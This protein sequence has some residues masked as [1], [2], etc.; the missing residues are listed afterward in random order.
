MAGIIDFLL[1]R[2]ND[3][4]RGNGI[5]EQTVSEQVDMSSTDYVRDKISNTK[6]LE[7]KTNLLGGRGSVDA[8]Q[9]LN[10]GKV[11]YSPEDLYRL[12]DGDKTQLGQLLGRMK[13]QY[14][15]DETF[16]ENEEMSH[17]S[18][19]GSVIDT[20]ADDVC[21][22]DERTGH[23]VDIEA[24][25]EKLK[26]FL[27]DFLENNVKI[28][29]RIW[30]WVNE[31]IKNGD[32]KLHRREYYAGAENSGI[33]SVYYEDVLNP[34]LVSRIE[35]MGNVLGYEDCE[36]KDSL[37]VASNG[38]DST[39][40][41]EAPSEFVHFISAKLSRRERVL[42]KVRDKNTGKSESVTCFKVVGTSILDNVRYIY[43]IINLLDNM[44]IMSRVARSTQYNL[45]KVEVG[46]ASPGDTQRILMDV[47][48]RLEGSTKMKKNVG[49]RTDPSP[50]PI[51]SNVYV[52]TREGKGD[53]QIESVGDNV[54]VH[55]ITDI[56]YFKDKEFAALKVPKQYMGFDESLSALGNSSLSKIDL[57]YAR[58]VQRVQNIALNGIKALCNNYLEFRGR[59]S[60]V[61]QFRIRMRPISTSE[62]SGRV[63]ELIT[64]LQAVDSSSGMLEQYKDYIDKAKWF[65]AMLGLIS[66]SP[67]EIGSKEFLQMLQ[68][69]KNGTYDEAKYKK[70]EKPEDDERW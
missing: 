6:I 51:N 12:L 24:D 9:T 68:E 30:T 61:N 13:N 25:N 11:S 15:Y 41:F 70:A 39:A 17:D 8:I 40:V 64:N 36:P 2:R 44:L 65:K 50:I 26:K 35:Y 55:S 52:V 20:I 54:D 58:S 56:D 16:R 21:Q 34:Y 59:K 19:I 60:D 5:G 66:I 32:F 38:V 45:V 22:A 14:S 18:I 43:R 49:M 4:N 42:V 31:I 48:R 10:E 46:N 62:N 23:V 47:R 57:R 53:V 29:D 33:K 7:D 28:E 69:M 37:E 67:D 1:G 63:E 3:T 27:Q